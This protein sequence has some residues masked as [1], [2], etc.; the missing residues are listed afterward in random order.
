MNNKKPRAAVVNIHIND[1]EEIIPVWDEKQQKMS[2]KVLKSGHQISAKKVEL[3]THYDRKN[4]PKILN[5]IEFDRSSDF[6]FTMSEAF[7][8]YT[9]VWGIDTNKRDVFGLQANVSGITV[10]STDGNNDFY[11]VAV[12]L[13]GETEGN[14]ELFA[15]RRFIT[16][17]ERTLVEQSSCKFAL[18]VD[19]ELSLI[20][21]INERKIPV[22]GDF[23]LPPNWK[24]IYAT[25]DS[26][27]ENI[28]NKILSCSD[29]KATEIL[30]KFSSKKFNIDIQEIFKPVENEEKSKITMMQFERKA[31]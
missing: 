26:G 19:S 31:E 11:P 10:C 14:A 29:R 20:P 27:K 3:S 13:F 8:Q 18:I 6:T 7:K 15:W 2:I 30:R 4:K 9:Q 17:I 22:H 1:G 16:Y 24:L 28:L 25:S 12:L 21:S 5:K 23:Y